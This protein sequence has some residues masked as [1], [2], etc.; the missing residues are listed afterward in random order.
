MLEA[1]KGHPSLK[2]EMLRFSPG[3]CPVCRERVL[4]PSPG[5]GVLLVSGRAGEGA[6]TNSSSLSA[7][8]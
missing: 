4:G 6:G 3:P 5:K 7:A 8:E 1:P 2:D